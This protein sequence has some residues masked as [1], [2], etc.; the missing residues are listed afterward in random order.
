MKSQPAEFPPGELVDRLD[1]F[2]PGFREAW[3]SEDCLFRADDGTDSLCGVFAEYSLF[4]RERAETVTASTW[5]QIA[6]FVNDIVGG[7]D[8]VLDEAACVCFLEGLAAPNHPLARWLEGEASEFWREWEGAE[9]EL[10]PVELDLA[11]ITSI[12]ALHQELATHLRFP[13]YYGQNWDA[14]EEC[15][16]D[17]TIRV[18]KRISISGFSTLSRQWPRDAEILREILAAAGFE[19]EIQV[20]WCG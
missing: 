12:E 19:R 13:D 18:P 8:P 3:L 17:L 7:R 15:I 20:D 1:R 5:K 16:T 11:A 2:T 10:E 9:A 4:V 14:F 6:A